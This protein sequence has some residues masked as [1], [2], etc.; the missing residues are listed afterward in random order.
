LIGRECLR[1]PKRVASDLLAARRELDAKNIFAYDTNF[2]DVLS[3]APWHCDT[4]ALHVAH[5]T[6]RVA[7]CGRIAA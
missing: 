1:A 4:V 7:R 2:I 6:S 5:E 3:R